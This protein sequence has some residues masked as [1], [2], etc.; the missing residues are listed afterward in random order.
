[1]HNAI[2]P[3]SLGFK[4]DRLKNGVLENHISP[5]KGSICL[6]GLSQS[7][8]LWRAC[9][10]KEVF[11]DKSPQICIHNAQFIQNVKCT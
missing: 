4:P 5:V 8:I 9:F 7:A 1:M 10:D 6:E 2:N 11:V 3:V